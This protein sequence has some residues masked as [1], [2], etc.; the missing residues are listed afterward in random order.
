MF[1]HLPA[2]AVIDVPLSKALK[3]LKAIFFTLKNY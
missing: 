3:L 2:T 1:V